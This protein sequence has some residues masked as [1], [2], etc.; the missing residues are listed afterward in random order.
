[1]HAITTRRLRAIITHANTL[2]NVTIARASAFAKKTNVMCVAVK[3]QVL[4]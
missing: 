1:M 2:K 3:V 4:T